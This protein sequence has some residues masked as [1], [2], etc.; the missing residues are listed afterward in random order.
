M[1]EHLQYPIGKF[2]P[3]AV[4][5]LE[6]INQSI[7]EISYLPQQMRIAVRH[8]NQI[9]LNTPYRPGGWTLRQVCHHVLDSHMNGFIRLK[10]AL[11][12][13]QPIIKP[14][15]ES[16]W[17]KLPDY[18]LELVDTLDQ[19]A[20]LHKRWAFILETL[21][22]EDFERQYFHPEKERLLTLAE[23]TANY[24]WHGRHHV[25]HITSLR[26]RMSW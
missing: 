5:S 24:A 12:E 20:L 8:L 19:L 9:Q 26:E 1:S 2:E 14:Y 10:L 21:S 6:E 3:R 4:Y 25:A 22:K 7:T 15:T 16:E 17:A 18:D 13:H 11:T 23:S